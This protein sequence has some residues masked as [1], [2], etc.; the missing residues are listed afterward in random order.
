MIGWTIS[1]RRLMAYEKACRDQAAE[2]T[3]D[4]YREELIKLADSFHERRVEHLGAS[5]SIFQ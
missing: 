5:A 3:D 4:Q 2:A 1:E